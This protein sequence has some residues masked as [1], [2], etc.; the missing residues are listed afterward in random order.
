VIVFL[1]TH[2]VVAL[3]DGR[4]E[5]FGRASKRLL[6]AADLRW[7]P[8]VAVELALL[9]EIGRVTV[10]SEQIL[11]RVAADLGAFEAND[12]FSAV[13]ARATRLT[14]TRDPLDRLI[15][16]HAELHDAPLV[17]RDARIAEHY[18]RAVW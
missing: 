13:A 1:D 5:V 8:A 3:H 6:S 12:S 9:H 11:A 18:P 14:W 15:V 16:A 2:A 17:S 7:S 10:S 4:T